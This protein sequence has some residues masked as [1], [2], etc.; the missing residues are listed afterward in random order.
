MR[1][2]PGTIP[3]MR[4]LVAAPEA[5]ACHFWI[6]RRF[7]NPEPPKIMNAV[8][9][10]EAGPGFWQARISQSSIHCHAVA[11]GENRI[12]DQLHA[13]PVPVVGF[14]RKRFWS[15]VVMPIGAAIRR[16]RAPCRA[17]DPCCPHLAQTDAA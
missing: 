15:T 12:A 5:G 9:G 7:V 6:R 14:E 8:A 17:R 3:G 10:A 1:Y 2:F 13:H 11:I 4:S 16:V